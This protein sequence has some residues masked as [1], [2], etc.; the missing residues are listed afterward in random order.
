MIKQFTYAKLCK[1]GGDMRKWIKSKLLG[2]ENIMQVEYTIQ[3]GD[4]LTMPL[5]LKSFDNISLNICIINFAKG[6]IDDANKH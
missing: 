3:M 1:L 6:I 2:M 5:F 4:S